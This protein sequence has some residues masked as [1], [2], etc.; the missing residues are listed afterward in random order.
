M[1]ASNSTAAHA[2]HAAPTALAQITSSE[3]EKK[4]NEFLTESLPL[5][6]PLDALPYVDALPPDQQQEVQQ[7]L[8]QEMAAIAKEN[9]N[10][11]PPDYL[12]DFQVPKTPLLDDAESM[13][14][15]EFQRKAKG[16][17]IPELDL[18]RYSS[19]SRPSGQK[20]S[21]LKEWEKCL[22]QCQQLLQHA[23]VSHVNLEL[24]VAH[25]APSWQRHIKN[26]SQ[27]SER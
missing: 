12:A 25:A 11:G 15:K 8:Q 3:P 27:T 13:L 24:M 16:E 6:F 26:L 20:A 14:G 9:D 5:S 17:P 7:L 23:A 18:E 19:F 4:K 21:D 22:V 2:A 10:D 1:S